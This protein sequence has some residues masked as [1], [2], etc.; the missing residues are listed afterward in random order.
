MDLSKLPQGQYYVK[1][2]S[3]ERVEIQKIVH[4]K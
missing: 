3:G 1:V 4:F 2:V